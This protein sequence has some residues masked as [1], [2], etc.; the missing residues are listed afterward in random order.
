MRSQ[1]MS[2]TWLREERKPKGCE[3]CG[4]DD[5]V[6]WSENRLGDRNA[7]LCAKCRRIYRG[8]L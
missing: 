7:V 6:Q 5:D 1:E 4:S 8:Q 3:Y 2:D